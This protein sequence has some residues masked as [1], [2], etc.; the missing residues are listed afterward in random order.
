ME[1]T[2][3]TIFI[4]LALALGFVG[5]AV[6]IPGTTDTEIVYKDKIVEK[7]VEVAVEKLVEIPS[8]DMLSLAVDAFLI[9]V[10]NEEDEA[11]N[12]VDVL[13]NYNF[14]EVEV[15]KVYDEY[16][17]EFNDDEKVVEFSIRLRFKEEGVQSEK[18]T[19]DVRVIFE[20][21]ED[22]EVEVL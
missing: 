8:P 15:S 7:E 4:I 9:A 14:D 16:S 13:G 1:N 17:V 3:V 2:I 6:L 21:G 12:D 5:G 11:G 10:E 20:E 18:E 19:Y 22:T